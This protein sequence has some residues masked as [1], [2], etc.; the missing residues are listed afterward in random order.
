MNILVMAA[1]A[2]ERDAVLRGL[3]ASK[4][5]N[6]AI[7][8]VGAAAAAA[9]TATL[10]AAA[11]YDLV[12]SAGIAGGFVGRAEV[13]SIVIADAAIAADLGAQTPDGFRS[14]DQLGFGSSQVPVDVGLA[15]RLA[16]A[17]RA[18][19]GPVYTGTILTVST[20]TGTAETAAEL[21]AR[22]PGATAEA[23]EGYG[24]GMAAYQSGIPFLEIRAISNAVGPRDRSA[25]R[26][27]E[28]LH[29]LEAASKT[30]REV[31]Q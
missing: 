3:H 14:L 11:T 31:L 30:L 8:G 29:A 27:E 4:D 7:A 26:I 16:E 13:G 25:W 21:V 19:G 24:V 28:A 22:V 9:Q 17:L 23:M 5:F 10:L 1:V 12:I 2:L 18:A 6:V 20:V 15:K